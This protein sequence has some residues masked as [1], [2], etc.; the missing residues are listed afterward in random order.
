MDLANA[1]DEA[2]FK[3]LLQAVKPINTLVYGV[4]DIE[5]QLFGQGNASDRPEADCEDASC[6]RRGRIFRFDVMSAVHVGEDSCVIE[7][8]DTS[9]AQMTL[10]LFASDL[11]PVAR[12]ALA[13]GF[14]AALESRKAGSK[15]TSACWKDFSAAVAAE[16]L[17]E[18]RRR[19]QSASFGSSSSAL[20]SGAS[21][22]SRHLHGARGGVV[23]CRPGQRTLEVLE[24]ERRV[25]GTSGWKS[26]FLPT[27]GELS[28][29]WVDASGCRHPHLIPTLRRDEVIKRTMPPCQLEH[30][31]FQSTSDWILVRST[32]VT[33]ENG[34]QYGVAWN[35]STWDEKPGLLD[36]L[37]RRRWMR[38]YT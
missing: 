17:A 20:G 34:W 14:L 15:E 19:P 33:D 18:R 30:S 32:G 10:P 27:D 24:I 35:A 8:E 16:R 3:L 12:K 9:G 38:T 37:R 26:P 5:R 1:I 6:Q 25:L 4:Q 21:S 7:L 22:T 31:L 23:E 13:D 11:G 28:W 29:R 2:A 36:A